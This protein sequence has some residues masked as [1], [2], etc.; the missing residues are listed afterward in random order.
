MMMPSA[1]GHDDDRVI[2]AAVVGGEIAIAAGGDV[3]ASAI[4]FLLLLLL[5]P[6]GFVSLA[7]PAPLLAA[8]PSLAYNR[9]PKEPVA[10]PDEGNGCDHDDDD[11]DDENGVLAIRR[12]ASPESALRAPSAPLCN[13]QL[14]PFDKIR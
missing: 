14:E 7:P 13:F 9:W 10:G 5:L 12:R 8:F 1:P 2:H 11:D 3:M 4:D 6:S